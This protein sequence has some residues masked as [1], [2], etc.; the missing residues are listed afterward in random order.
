MPAE[1]KKVGQELGEVRSALPLERLEVYL[2][3]NVRGYSG[4]LEVQ[5]FKVCTRYP[6]RTSL[7][8]YIVW[9]GKLA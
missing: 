1:E 3:E 2:K 6:A 7:I 5:Q 8:R 4:P 9:P